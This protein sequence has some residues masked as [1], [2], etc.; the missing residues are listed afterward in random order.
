MFELE[1]YSKKWIRGYFDSEALPSKATPESTSRLNKFTEKL[2]FACPDNTNRLFSWHLRF[3][4]GAGRIY[5]FPV[6]NLKKIIIG[7]IGYKID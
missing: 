1:D 5:F 3:T 4:P 2:T 6:D 7:Y